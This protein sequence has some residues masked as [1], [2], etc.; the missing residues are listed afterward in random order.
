[1][2]RRCRLL[3]VRP[4]PTAAVVAGKQLQRAWGDAEEVAARR[5]HVLRAAHS[6]RKKASKRS[7]LLSG[8]VAQS[9]CVC[10]CVL[11][12]PSCFCV[13]LLLFAGV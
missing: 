1:M 12:F 6:A 8:A 4:L 5:G 7:A 10:V 3:Y 9:L 2:P 13:H 11:S